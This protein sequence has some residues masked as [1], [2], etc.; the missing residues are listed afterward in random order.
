MKKLM[1]ACAAI[2]LTGAMGMAQAADI[3]QAPV[4][5]DL[6]SGSNVFSRVIDSRNAGN[7]FTDRYDFTAT[8][9]SSL[10]AF[11]SALATPPLTQGVSLT[12]FTLYTSGGSSLQDGTKV[13]SGPINLWTNAAANLQAANYYLLVSGSVLGNGVARYDGALDLKP[14]AAVP[15]PET[16]GMLLGGLAVLGMVARRRKSDSAA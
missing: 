3:S 10:S 15:E 7:T 6:S 4:T 11:V 8:A 16:Y 2:A 12:G 1:T 14:A 13:F 9:G 5:I